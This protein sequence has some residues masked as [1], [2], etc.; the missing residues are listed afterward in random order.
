MDIRPL[1]SHGR[2]FIGVL[3]VTF[4]RHG[5]PCLHQCHMVMLEMDLLDLERK[6]AQQARNEALSLAYPSAIVGPA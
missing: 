1:Q 4:R 3:T 2:G 6:M 5:M